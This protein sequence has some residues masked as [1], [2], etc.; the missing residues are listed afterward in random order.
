MAATAPVDLVSAAAH[1]A[2]AGRADGSAAARRAR[3]SRASGAP[4]GARSSSAFH[5][6][7]WTAET[8]HGPWRSPMEREWRG[9]PP[10]FR[11]R[12]SRR[13]TCRFAC[14]RVCR[15]RASTRP[16]SGLRACRTEP[17][18][19]SVSSRSSTARGDDHPPPVARRPSRKIPANS[20]P[21]SSADDPPPARY[22]RAGD[23]PRTRSAK[24]S[25]GSFSRA[26]ARRAADDRPL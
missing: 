24:S 11:R 12:E 19:C 13:A 7:C 15:P 20:S 5:V 23:R 2:E 1:G 26:C 9:S 22:Q 17:R 16:F 10:F 14:R 3:H 4:Q 8:R 6:R 25:R 21:I 18:R